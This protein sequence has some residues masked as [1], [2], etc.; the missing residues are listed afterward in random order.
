MTLYL[1]YRP[2]VLEELDLTSVRETLKKLVVSGQIPHAILFS[3]P[4]G[5]GKTSAARILAKAINCEHPGKDGE[6]CNK[7]NQCKAINEGSHLDIIELDA[8]SNRGIDDIRSLRE[9][10][11]LAPAMG[12]K[13][14]YIVDEAHM[15]TT[16]ASN[17]LLKTLEEPPS[18]VVFILATTNPEKLI[19]TVRSRT[20]TVPFSKPTTEEI[21]RS[22][23][24]VVKGEKIKI[25]SETLA[26]IAETSGDSFRDAIKILESFTLE[27][28]SA[29]FKNSLFPTDSV[30]E[31]LKHLMAKDAKAA[32]MEVEKV[33]SQGVS[34]EVYIKSLLSRIRLA[35][36]SQV[37]VGEE[38]KDLGTPSDLIELTKILSKN[39]SVM[40]DVPIAQ[41]PLEISVI[42]WCKGDNSDKTREEKTEKKDTAAQA[43]E[44]KEV[45]SENLASSQDLEH[46]KWTKILSAVK[47]RNKSVEALLR[48]ARPISFDG[49]T[50]QL[51]VFYSFHKERLE[52]SPHR[53]ILDE[54]IAEVFGKGIRVICT[55]TAPPEVAL[56]ETKS[57]EGIVLTESNSP[58]IKD[59]LTDGGG[60]DI[61][62][63]AK[64]MFGS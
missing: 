38:R 57:Q 43:L 12:N 36:L 21:L 48:S 47:P 44:K 27:G 20:T 33:I 17:A 34:M 3:G 2:K 49:Q 40:K 7:C 56:E 39:L 63:A 6:P 13:K 37:G 61:I 9:A 18:H 5:L 24:R 50:L 31:F 19:E 59:L 15:L 60:E 64:E 54:I 58:E 52:A 11:K 41:L 46:D 29:V 4:K 51:G 62:K 45:K 55:L 28:E 14:I 53:Q 35:I 30:E 16:E 42:E 10:V 22:L 23:E 8:A 32:L 1:K 26:N 25:A